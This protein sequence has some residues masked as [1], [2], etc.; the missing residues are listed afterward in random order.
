MTVPATDHEHPPRPG[1]L[2]QVIV[3]AAIWLL[4]AFLFVVTYSRLSRTSGDATWPHLSVIAATVAVWLAWRLAAAGARSRA[5][6]AFS[7]LLAGAILL[8]QLAFYASVLV[9]LM[10]WGRV[11]RWPILRMYLG[12]WAGD[13]LRVLGVEPALAAFGIATVGLASLVAVAWLLRRLCWPRAVR[14][15]TSPVLVAVL[16]LATTG[17]LTERGYQVVIG[18]WVERAEPLTLALSPPA[19]RA[20]VPH[21]ER[22]LSIQ[23]ATD[24]A[25][26]QRYRPSDA[27]P[28]TSPRNPATS[29]RHIQAS[30]EP[31]TGISKWPQEWL[32]LPSPATRDLPDEA[33]AG[34][35]R[36]ARYDTPSSTMQ[37]ALWRSRSSVADASSRLAGKA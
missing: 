35:A 24:K 2:V 1:L 19:E 11:P 16:L 15:R 33:A 36:G 9:G 37:Y 25:A 27:K 5:L 26:A 13:F 21:V 34:A 28:V 18:A 31:R 3:E 6:D 4:P 29:C 22:G 8:A 14:A 30:R 17:A 7:I 12:P 23:S 10:S 32:D 20:V